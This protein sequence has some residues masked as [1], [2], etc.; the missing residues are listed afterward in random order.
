M[1]RQIEKNSK[2]KFS[3][4]FQ[5]SVVH[6][7]ILSSCSRSL[8]HFVLAIK[9]TV[10]HCFPACY[11]W[12]DKDKGANQFSTITEDIVNEMLHVGI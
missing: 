5:H 11:F 8:V 3:T 9:A 2:F 7:S 4:I 6:Y 1:M 10:S 12:L